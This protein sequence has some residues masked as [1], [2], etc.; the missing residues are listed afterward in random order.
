MEI[1]IIDDKYFQCISYTT[2]H[3]KFSVWIHKEKCGYELQYDHQSFD[4]DGY[5]ED[6]YYDSIPISKIES[7]KEVFYSEFDKVSDI[8]KRFVGEKVF[9][10][11][12]SAIEV[13]G[14]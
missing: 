2:H 6:D 8:Y 10:K 7:I 9:G 12:L 5:L 11:V 3:T 14:C 13:S 4:D 1:E